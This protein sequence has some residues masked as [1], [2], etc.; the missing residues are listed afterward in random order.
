ML[1]YQPIKELQLSAEQE[2]EYNLLH[3]LFNFCQFLLS[4]YFCSYRESVASIYQLNELSHTGMQISFSSAHNHFWISVSCIVIG[5]GK[6][7][8]NYL[9]R[10]ILEMSRRW[11]IFLMA[12]ICGNRLKQNSVLNPVRKDIQAYKSWQS[13][14]LSTNSS[15]E[16]RG[17]PPAEPKKMFKLHRTRHKIS[18]HQSLYSFYSREN[19]LL[20]YLILSAWL[21][22]TWQFILYN[23]YQDNSLACFDRRHHWTLTWLR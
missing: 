17:L 4:W 15:F 16:G 11:T 10:E 8:K 19:E 12:A 6:N 21:L 23:H 20:L 7:P 18:S 9:G 14:T 13:R 3:N 2:K 22:I 5:W 1:N